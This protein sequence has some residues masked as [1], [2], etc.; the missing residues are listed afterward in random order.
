MC[1]NSY[2]VN[3]RIKR[4]E[5]GLAVVLSVLVAA[6]AVYSNVKKGE[7]YRG[8][9]NYLETLSADS[10]DHY[11]A[12]VKQSTQLISEIIEGELDKGS[13]ELVI[14]RIEVLTSEN[15]GYV[16]SLRMIYNDGFWSGSMV[17]KLPPENVT[18]FTFGVRAIIEANGTVTYINISIEEVGGPQQSEE[19]LSSTINLNLKEVSPENG[20]PEIPTPIAS[21]L[22]I[23]ATSLL[24]IAQ[25][26]I[27]GVPICFA[28]LGV[29]IL[30]DRGIIPLWK[31]MLRRSK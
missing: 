28:S 16:K 5:I 17:C 11:S 20:T 14:N 19:N 12:D 18:S 9:L 7:H 8:N 21:V 30:V 26:L 2:G 4:R 10:K 15:L 25:G 23:L 3:M 22:H 1:D 31:S 6:S 27:I 24:W 13:F 29:V